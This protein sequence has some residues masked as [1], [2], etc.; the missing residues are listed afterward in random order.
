MKTKL[1]FTL[2]LIAVMGTQASAITIIIKGGGRNQLFNYVEVTP[3]K[4]I[5]KGAG[6]IVCP[7]TYA[8]VQSYART[9][10]HPLQ[11]VTDFVLKQVENGAAKG[12][13][14]YEDD[15]PVTWSMDDNEGLQI[16]I[17]EGAV[18]GLKEY[19]EKE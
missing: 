1:L 3:A 12:E 6:Y 17:E 2:I 18:K 11:D 8:A 13:V 16:D 10:W 4:V 19:E 5:C 9:V 15:L 7:I 14:K